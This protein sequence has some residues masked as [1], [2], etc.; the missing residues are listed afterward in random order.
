MQTAQALTRPI[1]TVLIVAT[2]C[3]I[4]IRSNLAITSD[5]FITIAAMIIAF[6]F[7]QRAAESNTTVVADRRQNNENR[8]DSG[9]RVRSNGGDIPPTAT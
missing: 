3:Y 1:V 4:A 9:S 6:W 7:G 2:M 8:T 5:Q